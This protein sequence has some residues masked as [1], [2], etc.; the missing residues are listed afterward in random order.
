MDQ[1]NRYA[2]LDL[3]EADLIAG[4]RHVLVAYIMKPKKGFGGYLETAAHFAR[5]PMWTYRPP[6]I[7]PVASMRWFTRSTKPAS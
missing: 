1:S 3:K 7:S 4:G 6:M 5:A 2:R